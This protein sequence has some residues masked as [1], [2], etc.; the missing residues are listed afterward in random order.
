L[1]W[2]AAGLA[3]ALFTLCNLAPRA[4][5]N[6]TWYRAHFPNYPRKRRILIPGVY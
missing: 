4:V 1:T 5:A 2:S 3:F 6:Q